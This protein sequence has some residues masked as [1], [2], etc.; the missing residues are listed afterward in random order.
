[1]IFDSINYL[2]L[3]SIIASQQRTIEAL[4]ELLYEIKGVQRDAEVAGVG[5]FKFKW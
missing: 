2:T 5:D 3:L 4:T 1:M